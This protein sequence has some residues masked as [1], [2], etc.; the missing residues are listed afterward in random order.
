MTEENSRIVTIK[1]SWYRVVEISGLTSEEEDA[2]FEYFEKKYP[3]HEVDGTVGTPYK[4]MV[5]DMRAL[6][7]AGEI[8]LYC[9]NAGM[10]VTG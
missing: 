7:L 4:I 1:P 10:V 6:Y 5:S 3:T 9:T 8:A 2:L